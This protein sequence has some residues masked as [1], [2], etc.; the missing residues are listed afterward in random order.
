MLTLYPR[1]QRCCHEEPAHDLPSFHL[2]TAKIDNVT[3]I[4][5]SLVA[6]PI[7]TAENLD[8]QLKV[9]LTPDTFAADPP[10]ALHH[11]WKQTLQ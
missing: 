3:G 4:D 1:P 5:Y 9:R 7:I 2:V 11:P 6:P 8:G 10:G